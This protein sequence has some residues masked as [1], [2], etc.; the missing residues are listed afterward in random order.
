M[1]ERKAFAQM[2]ELRLDSLVQRMKLVSIGTYNNNL[3]R[4]DFDL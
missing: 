1:K 3:I 4:V 2:F